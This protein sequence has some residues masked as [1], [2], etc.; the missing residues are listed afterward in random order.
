[1]LHIMRTCPY[2]ERDELVAV[3]VAMVGPM[4]FNR[5]QLEVLLGVALERLARNG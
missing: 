3:G 4:R 2:E 1:L 5:A